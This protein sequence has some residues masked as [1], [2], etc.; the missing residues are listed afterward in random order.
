M[1]NTVVISITYVDNAR[2]HGH[3]LVVITNPPPPTRN[4]IIPSSVYRVF[5][6]YM[7]IVSVQ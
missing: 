4:T 7:Y 6:Y 1:N 2:A 5:K 3:C